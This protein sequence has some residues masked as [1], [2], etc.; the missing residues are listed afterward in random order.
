M[1]LMLAGV[2]RPSSEERLALGSVRPMVRAPHSHPCQPLRESRWRCPALSR[3]RRR[4]LRYRGRMSTAKPA[5]FWSY[6]H[7]DDEKARGGIL[8]LAKLISDEYSLLKGEEL[9]LF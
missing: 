5:A 6:A 9:R 3:L 1:G 4:A 2:R 7:E 8:E